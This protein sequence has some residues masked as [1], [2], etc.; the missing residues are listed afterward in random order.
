M[1]DMER[2]GLVTRREGNNFNYYDPTQAGRS[3]LEKNS[4]LLDELE[5][6][7]WMYD[8]ARRKED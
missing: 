7:Y 5:K 6:A 2:A 1:K 3:F 8:R 4:P